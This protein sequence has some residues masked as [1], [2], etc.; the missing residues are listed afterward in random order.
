MSLVIKTIVSMPFAE[1]TYLVWLDNWKQCVVVDPGLDPESIQ[2]CIAE[3]E[4]SV[5]AILNTHGHT[6]HIAGN[7]FMKKL[8]PQAP[9]IIGEGDAPMLTDPDLN[10]SR[11]YGIDIVSPPADQ[12][13]KE[14]ETLHLGGM[15][16][17]ILDIPGHSPGHIVFVLKEH[18]I[19]LGGDVLFREGIGR[20]DFPGGSFQTL[21]KGIRGK[22]FTLDPDFVVYPGHGPVTKIG[23]EKKANPFVGEQASRQW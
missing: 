8:L 12:T 16:L 6:D 9:I 10:L 4:L 22:L 14:G 13:V 19:V 18:K 3:N 23:H 1:N 20:T 21:A 15:D 11:S 7:D 17:E 5:V 2:D